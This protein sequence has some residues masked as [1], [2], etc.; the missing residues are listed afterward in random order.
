MIKSRVVSLACF[1]FL[2]TASSFGAPSEDTSDQNLEESESKSLYISLGLSA[3]GSLG[4][5]FIT[6]TVGGGP[7]LHI[8]ALLPSGFQIGGF[9]RYR[10]TGGTGSE[11]VTINLFS[12][13]IFGIEGGY[14]LPLN[15]SAI[16]R[17]GVRP[18]YVVTEGLGSFLF[19]PI[20]VGHLQTP[21][22]GADVGLDFRLGSSLLLGLELSYF[23]VFGGQADYEPILSQPRK[24]DVAGFSLLDAALVFG[25]QI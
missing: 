1:F 12:T 13:S 17:V 11:G 8:G 5:S 24:M 21:A 23:Y 16:F 19:L 7:S 6:T 22:I 3:M 2:T 25:V 9:Y 14:E 4:E 10:F 18:A 15:E 20:S